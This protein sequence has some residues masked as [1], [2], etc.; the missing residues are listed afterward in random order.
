VNLSQRIGKLE[1]GSGGG[2]CPHGIRVVWP[3]DEKMRRPACPRLAWTVACPGL[4]SESY[5]PIGRKGGSCEPGKQ[6]K[7]V[8]AGLRLR[9]KLHPRLQSGMAAGGREA[10]QRAGGVP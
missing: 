7:R 10:A 3:S 1:R 6:A 9:R 2:H 4:S 8:R 5:V